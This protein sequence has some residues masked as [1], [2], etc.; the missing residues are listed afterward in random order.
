MAEDFWTNDPE[1]S[2]MSDQYRAAIIQECKVQAE[3]CQYTSTA[4]YELD[5]L[6]I[7]IGAIA[8]FKLFYDSCTLLASILAFIAGVLPSVYEKLALQSHVNEIF[9]QAGQY[10]NLE[11]TPVRD[12]DCMNIE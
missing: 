10:K 8:S 1:R 2:V 9:A 11:N 5:I 3:S 7:S 12:K 4:L 6:P